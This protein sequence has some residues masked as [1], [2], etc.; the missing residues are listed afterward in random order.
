MIYLDL[1]GVD[2]H[3]TGGLAAHLAAAL[4]SRYVILKVDKANSEERES[5][6]VED[7][8]IADFVERY[9][10]HAFDCGATEM[11]ALVR[12]STQALRT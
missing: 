7:D 10:K 4:Q 9:L 8:E 1:P 2:R 5:T 12:Q 6:C 11:V 3:T